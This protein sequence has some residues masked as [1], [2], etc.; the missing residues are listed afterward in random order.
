[1]KQTDVPI[2][3]K[4]SLTIAEASAYFGIGRDRLYD[5]C[6]GIQNADWLLRNGNRWL[7]KRRLF[8][9]LLDKTDTI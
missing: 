3:E 7:I 2:S 5:M 6:H 8:E 9:E 4:Y 1:M